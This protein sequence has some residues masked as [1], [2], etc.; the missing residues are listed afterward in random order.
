MP[1]I[2]HEAGLA[3]QNVNHLADP[4]RP[5]H[6]PRPTGGGAQPHHLWTIFRE[7]KSNG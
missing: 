4:S 3:G 2:N 7:S 1:P 5:V 6:A